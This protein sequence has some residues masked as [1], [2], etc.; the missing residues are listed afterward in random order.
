[1]DR[2]LIDYI[3]ERD[4]QRHE[5]VTAALDTLTPTQR[6]VI[7]AAAVMGYVQGTQAPPGEAIPPDSVIL[8]RVIAACL[9]MSD[10]YPAIAALD[11]P[12]DQE[13]TTP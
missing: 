6:A 2:Q 4:R 5:Q 8:H 3:A 11:Q 9:A 10:L 7:K 12:G 13:G 1:M